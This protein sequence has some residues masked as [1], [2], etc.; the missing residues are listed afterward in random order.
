[1]LL[2]CVI[3]LTDVYLGHCSKGPHC[4]YI[5]DP[6]K[7]AICPAYMATGT[8]P[9]GSNC[10]LSHHV[11]AERVPACVHFQH[12]RCSKADCRYAHVLVSPGNG[13]ICRRFAIN[14][15]CEKGAQ[16]GERHVFECPDYASTGTCSRKKCRL[17]HVDRA[18][19]I[20]KHVAR[21]GPSPATESKGTTSDVSSDEARGPGRQ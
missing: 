12:G 13:D 11:T 15:Y 20:R 17:R 4:P 9:A 18:G 6:A 7:V 3:D 21:A 1:M 8:C 14:G 19:Q 10:D 5:H 16:C 2:T